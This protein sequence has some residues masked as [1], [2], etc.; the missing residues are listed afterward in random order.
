MNRSLTCRILASPRSPFTIWPVFVL[1][2]LI[3]GISF[4][5]F[6]FFLFFSLLNYPAKIYFLK[7]ISLTHL[8][9]PAF[10]FPH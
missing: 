8:S 2:Y 10:P 5:F 9:F 3:L 7:K 1:P 6:F 4:F